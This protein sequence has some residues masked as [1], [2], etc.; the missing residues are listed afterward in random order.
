MSDFDQYTV[1]TSPPGVK[2]YL[3]LR[4]IA[5]LSQKT[6]E[7]AAIGLTNTIFGVTIMHEGQPIGMGRIIGD[8]GCFFQ[9]V[10]IAVDPA[11]QKRGI[12]KKI[13]GELMH[14][15]RFAVPPSAY[16]SLIA[17]GAASS[18]YAQFGFIPTAPA[19]IGMALKIE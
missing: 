19:A 18:L 4:M 13:M 7:A 5:G 12:G 2:D 9:V 14:H 15:L 16:V 11:H 17:D 10:D 3:R 1:V 8:R 6:S